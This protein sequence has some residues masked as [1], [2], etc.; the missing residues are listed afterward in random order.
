MTRGRG[1]IPPYGKHF[2]LVSLH[3]HPELANRAYYLKQDGS[4]FIRSDK[5]SKTWT[6]FY[7]PGSCDAATALGKPLPSLT[8][9]MAKLLDGIGQG[10]YQLE[11]P[12]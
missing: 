4:W 3:Y 6:I 7:R 5:K 11:C 1:Q 8:A 9:A 10:F 2:R 12:S